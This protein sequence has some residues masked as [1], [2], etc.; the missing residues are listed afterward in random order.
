M[1]LWRLAV[2]EIW[3]RR[4]GFVLATVAVATAIACL[5]GAQTLLQ[6][7]RLITQEILEQRRTEITAALVEKEEAVKR[8]GAEL[9]DAIRKQMLGLGFNVLILPAEQSRAELLLEGMTATMPESYVDKLAASSIVTVNHLLPSIS[10]RLE[11]PEHQR[12]V[13]LIGTRGEVPIQHRA[14]KKQLLEEVEPGKMVVGYQIQ[15]DLNLKPGDTVTFREKEFTISKTHAERGSTDDVTVWINLR[16]AQEMLGMQNLIHAILALECE[17][18]GDRISA[19]RAEISGILPGT[20]V[21][22]KYSEALTRAEARAQAKLTA[23]VALQQEQMAGMATL[24]SEQK[25][26]QQVEQRHADFAAVLVPLV[27]LAAA[28]I[29]FLLALQNVRQRTSEIGI[30]RAIGL[31]ARQIIIVFL[32]RAMLTGI[33]GG[34]IGVALGFFIGFRMGGTSELQLATSEL[35][36]AGHLTTTFIA[37]PILALILS[38]VAS[39]IPALMAAGQDPASILQSDL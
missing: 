27:V 3:H 30:L 2:R 31:K 37:A 36:A 29:I 32:S 35:F 28:V 10:K 39:W 13:I 1:T 4:L 12:E 34:I 38:A 6:A 9:Q 21:I 25:S 18:A 17:C 11:W 8:T 16:E 33:L 15:Q 24:D 14:L 5:T 23:E 7:D 19:I 20:Q 26:R 22:E